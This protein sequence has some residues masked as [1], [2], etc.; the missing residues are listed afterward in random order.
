[1]DIADIGKLIGLTVLSIATR[2]YL[3]KQKII[4][5]DINM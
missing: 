5:N 2:D 1:M 3:V 4:P